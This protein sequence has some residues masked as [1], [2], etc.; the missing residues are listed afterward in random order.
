MDASYRCSVIGVRSVR[1]AAPPSSAQ[2]SPSVTVTPDTGLVGGDVVTLAGTGFEPNSTVYYCEGV[3]ALTIDPNNCGVP[4]QPLTAD[5]TGAL[6]VGVTVFRFITPSTGGGTIDCAQPTA[7]CGFGAANLTLNGAIAPITFTPQPPTNTF[8]NQRDRD[9]TGRAP[10]CERQCMGVHVHRHVGWI[11]SNRDGWTRRVHELDSTITPHAVY[12]IRFGRARGY[13]PGVGVVQ[14]SAT[15]NTCYLRLPPGSVQ[16]P[17]RDRQ[18]TTRDGRSRSP[19]PSR[20][21]QVPASRA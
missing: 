9:R 3:V 2:T 10:R 8:A 18:Y 12:I 7:N 6:S 21:A 20:T 11:A 14:R 13:G 5:G 17:G 1:V 19:A 16:R 15:A 4:Y